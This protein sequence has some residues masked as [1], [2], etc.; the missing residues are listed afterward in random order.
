MTILRRYADEEAILDRALAIEPDDVETK[1]GACAVELDWKADTRA[2][3]S[4]DR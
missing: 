3:A 2:L 4:V 1:L